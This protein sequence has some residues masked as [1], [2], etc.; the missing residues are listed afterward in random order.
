MKHQYKLIGEMGG[1]LVVARRRRR[2]K[3]RPRIITTI[4]EDTFNPLLSGC[5]DSLVNLF[6]FLLVGVGGVSMVIPRPKTPGQRGFKVIHY[7]AQVHQGKSVAG[8]G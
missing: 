3:R 5:A 2:R 7:A 4:T 6:Q 1:Q 8:E